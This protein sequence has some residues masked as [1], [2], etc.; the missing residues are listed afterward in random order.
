MS[1]FLKIIFSCGSDL[2]MWLPNPNVEFST[3]FSEMEFIQNEQF[4][5]N[6]EFGRESE[7]ESA[8]QSNQNQQYYHSGDVYHERTTTVYDDGTMV[9]NIITGQ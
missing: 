5:Q 4:I 3:D 8:Q 1:T 6:D 7:Q 2:E 9:N